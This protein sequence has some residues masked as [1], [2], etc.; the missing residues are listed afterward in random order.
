MNNNQDLSLK[1]TCELPADHPLYNVLAP[2]HSTLVEATAEANTPEMIARKNGRKQ[3][4][5]CQQGLLA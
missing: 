4:I 1:E 5:L 2:M 3:E